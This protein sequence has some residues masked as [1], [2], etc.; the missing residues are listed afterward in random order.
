[1]AQPR[2]TY[3]NFL[4]DFIA[5]C[6]VKGTDYIPQ[7]FINFFADNYS[8]TYFIA[9]SRF[10]ADNDECGPELCRMPRY[11]YDALFNCKPEHQGSFLLMVQ[12]NWEYLTGQTTSICAHC[13]QELDDV[14]VERQPIVAYEFG[15]VIK[16]YENLSMDGADSIELPLC[17]ECSVKT[18]KKVMEVASISEATCHALPSFN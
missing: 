16:F 9:L 8:D 2:Y 7:D 14:L 5:Y 15:P 12:R 6:K 10:M 3:H 1:M 11:G 13:K 18:M 17:R 4:S